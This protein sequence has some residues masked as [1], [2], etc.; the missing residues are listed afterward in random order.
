MPPTT[1][2]SRNPIYTD[3]NLFTS[4]FYTFT[5][6]GGFTM[7]RRF[8]TIQMQPSAP[9]TRYD[10]TDAIQLLMDVS[11]FNAK[12]GLV[13]DA[14]NQNI[15]SS[16]YSDSVGRFPNDSITLTASDF[17]ANLTNASQIIS[18]GKYK[19]LYSDFQSYVRDYFGWSGGFASLFSN[20]ST[21]TIND[22]LVGGSDNTT[23]NNLSGAGLYALMKNSSAVDASGAYLLDMSGS[24]TI[25]NIN[26]LLRYAVDTDIFNNRD[27]E[28]KDW[29]GAVDSTTTPSG[30]PSSATS[31]NYNFGV[32]DGFMANDLIYIPAGTTIRLKLKIASETLLPLNNKGASFVTTNNTTNGDYSE[33][34]TATTELIS[35]VVTAPILI[36]LVNYKASPANA[37]AP[38]L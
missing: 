20:A 3:F 21:F 11:V 23:K 9:F 26:Q 6:A 37:D 32:G 15:T 19:T 10:V 27:P 8:G 22:G 13:K 25:S 14:N 1:D 30:D 34:T 38:W 12:L 7:E 4:Q 16:T 18:V 33:N 31:R 24:I 35:R 36:R 2:V 29:T 28:G 5:A 17:R